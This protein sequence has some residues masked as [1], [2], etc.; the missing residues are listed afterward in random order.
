MATTVCQRQT[1]GTCLRRWSSRAISPGPEPS[2][3]PTG[4]GKNSETSIEE[5]TRSSGSALL[6][7]FCPKQITRPTAGDLEI[8]RPDLTDKGARE[9]KLTVLEDE[10]DQMKQFRERPEQQE[11]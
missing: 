4:T 10:L 11:G 9:A 8:S 7:Q 1:S 5:R 3:T 2:T 6:N